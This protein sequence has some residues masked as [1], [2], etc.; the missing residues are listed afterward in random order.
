MGK[1][2]S[3][4]RRYF[5]V[6]FIL[7]HVFVGIGLSPQV[8]TEAPGYAQVILDE[9][10]GCY[11]PALERYARLVPV[12]PVVTTLDQARQGACV[13]DPEC[14]RDG[15]FCQWSSLMRQL[16]DQIGLIRRPSRWNPDGTWNW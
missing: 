1:V 13:P 6:M 14:V 5:I 7:F 4:A 10:H 8:S 11:Y 2:K 16:L 15:V 12:P 9:A 3:W